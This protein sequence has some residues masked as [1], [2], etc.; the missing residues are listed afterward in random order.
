[1]TLRKRIPFHHD[2]DIAANRF[3]LITTSMM[4]DNKIAETP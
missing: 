3:M 4:H 1:M 2:N